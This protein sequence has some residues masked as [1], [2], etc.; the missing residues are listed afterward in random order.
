MTRKWFHLALVSVVAAAAA[1]SLAA[2]TTSAGT[3]RSTHSSAAS[4][5]QQIGNVTTTLKINKF[6]RHG[7]RLVAVGT[8]VSHFQPT[9]ANPAG[10][11][12]AT[13]TQPFTATVTG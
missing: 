10:V 13:T 8:A 11:Q 5:V 4:G 3:A 9:P 7:S 2:S 6:V 12:P 1:L